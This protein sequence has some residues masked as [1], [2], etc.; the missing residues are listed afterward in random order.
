M[1]VHILQHVFDTNLLAVADAPDTVELEPL[2]DGT[3]EDEDSRSSRAADEIDALRIQMRYR[4][5]EHTVVV[6]VQQADAV[7][8]DE[9]CTIGL[10]S[11]EDTLFECSACLGLLAKSGRDDDKSPDAL[12]GTEIIDIVGTELSG[13]HQ[14]SQ[15]CLGDIFHIV[16]SLDAL[17][18]VFLGVDDMEFATETTVLDITHDRATRLMYVIGAADDDDAPRVEELFVNHRCKDTNKRIKNK[19]RYY[20]NS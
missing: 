10:A 3:L 20:N 15:F 7:R 12:L 6:T 13:N 16:E 18:F 19:E 5:G 11:V 17:Y 4:Q 1:I 2:D 8:S 9:G 14:H